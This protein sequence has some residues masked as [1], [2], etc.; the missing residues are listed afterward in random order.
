MWR[1]PR[2]AA[3]GYDWT[4]PEL[5][6]HIARVCERGCSTWCSSP[7]S[8]TSPT[9]IAAR[10][11]RR[12]ATPRRRPS[13]IRSRCFPAWRAVTKHI[14]LAATFS[15]SH[16]HP[17]YAARLWATLDHLTSGRAGWNVVTSHQ[18]QP[19][20]ANFGED[21]PPPTTATTARTSSSRSA[22]SCGR[23]GTRTP[24]SWTATAG[25]FAD[26]AKVHRIEHAGRFFKSRGPLNVVRSPQD[27]PAI[28]QAGTSAKGRDF[29]AKLRRRD[30]RHPA[31]AARTPGATSTT[32]RAAWP[33]SAATRRQCK[34][35][36]GMQPIVGATRSRGAR[37]SRTSTTRSCRSEGGMAILSAISTSTCRSSPLDATMADRTEP[38]A[39]A[40]A[41]ALPHD[42]RASR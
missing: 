23:A 26:A 31:A 39:A 1:H 18:P 20:D 17:F 41:D 25:V 2:T 10:S 36:F 30:L 35:L 21:R 22:A 24:W 16:Q 11:S 29:A 40:H 12:C 6:Q 37:D 27:G 42:R 33:S 4:R 28:L 34:I 5:Y 38:R 9:P 8:T 32:S 15:V 13:T 19:V 3:A 7:T 14:G